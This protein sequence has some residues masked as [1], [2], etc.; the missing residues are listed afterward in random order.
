MF[1]LMDWDETTKEKNNQPSEIL[2]NCEQK[3][4]KPTVYTRFINSLPKLVL[5]CATLR[6]CLIYTSEP[7]QPIGSIRCQWE[8][9]ENHSKVI[10]MSRDKTGE[11]SVLKANKTSGLGN[12]DGLMI[13]LT[14]SYISQKYRAHFQLW[15]V[16]KGDQPVLGILPGCRPL[17][18]I[19]VLAPC[20]FLPLY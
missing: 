14:V 15:K 7:T 9:N 3:M 20:L 5:T 18:I 11:S 4:I 6:G 17:P 10:L 2:V 19:L 13:I 16:N 12:D 8:I 1:K